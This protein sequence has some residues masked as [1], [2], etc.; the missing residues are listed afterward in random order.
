MDPFPNSIRVSDST[1]NSVKTHAGF[2]DISGSYKPHAEGRLS[3]D[4]GVVDIRYEKKIVWTLKWGRVLQC[5]KPH[6]KERMSADIG[7]VNI[8]IR[9]L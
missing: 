2:V 8:I 5:Y 3:A 6:V 4:I 7:V 1:L 9:Y